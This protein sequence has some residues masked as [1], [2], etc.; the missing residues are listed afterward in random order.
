MLYWD[1][2]AL[3]AFLITEKHSTRLRTH[4]Q[5]Q[6][7]STAYTAIITPLEFESAIQRRLSER[8]LSSREA[9]YARL[10]GVDFRKKAFLVPLDQNALDTALHIQK[11]YGLRPGD[12]IQLASARLGTDD[13]SRVVFLSLD[14]KLT[15]AAKREGF[16]TDGVL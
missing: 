1:T 7:S 16:Q 4:I 10:F 13:P 6:G 15:E 9:D 2:S 11:I 12:A 5:R 8:T 3:F 14:E